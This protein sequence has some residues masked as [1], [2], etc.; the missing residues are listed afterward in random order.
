MRYHGILF[1]NKLR[2]LAKMKFTDKFS[3]I[4]LGVLTFYLS[5]TLSYRRYSEIDTLNNPIV[6]AVQIKRGEVGENRV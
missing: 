4:K 6:Y 5:A 3:D 2:C 1:L